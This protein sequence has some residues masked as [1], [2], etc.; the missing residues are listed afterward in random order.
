MLKLPIQEEPQ[1]TWLVQGVRVR[2]LDS[3][4]HLAS[5]RG[6]SRGMCDIQ[7]VD[8]QES[9]KPSLREIRKIVEVIEYAE[10]A[11]TAGEMDEDTVTEMHDSA[12]LAIMN[13]FSVGNTEANG[14]LNK[15]WD[16]LLT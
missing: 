12:V 14:L 16:R 9:V 13:R 4:L 8:T 2:S 7:R 5:R 6:F 10:I 11:D 1:G 3:A 15:F